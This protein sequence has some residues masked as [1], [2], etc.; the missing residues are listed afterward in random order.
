MLVAERTWIGTLIT[1]IPQHLFGLPAVVLLVIAVFRRKRRLI[2][3]NALAVAFYVVVLMGFNVPLGLMRPVPGGPSVRVMTYNI[4][5]G[6]GGMDRIARNIRGVSPDVACLQETNPLGNAS[7]PFIRLTREFP[8]WHSA[9]FGDVAVFSKWPIVDCQVYPSSVGHTRSFLRVGLLAH[10]KRFDVVCL[11]MATAARPESASR[12]KGSLASYL[13]R[14]TSARSYQISELLRITS[15]VKGPLIVAG[16]FNTP[17]R[18][19]L[20]GRIAG[21]FRDS[22]R[23]VGW[24]FG[25]SFRTD[26]PVMR[27]D[28]VWAGSGTQPRACSSRAL[29]G[30][31]HRPV[32]A[33]LVIRK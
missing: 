11:H 6:L 8:Q 16:D 20:Y 19:R 26:L 15:G 18:G 24:G 29:V 23:S 27:I 12:H 9:T 31:D 28:Y 5:H 13:H 33:E 14:T 32:V 25:Y 4:H 17:P 21:N 30:S 1:Y 2:V 22:F 10:G 3:T 7:S